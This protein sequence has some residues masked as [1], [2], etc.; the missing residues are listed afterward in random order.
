MCENAIA[1]VSCS[2][3]V[4]FLIFLIFCLFTG[5]NTAIS[6]IAVKTKMLDEMGK[7]GKIFVDGLWIADAYIFN[8]GR[9]LT[10]N[11]Q[12]QGCPMKSRSW[13]TCNEGCARPQDDVNELPEH[14]PLSSATTVS[15]KR[16]RDDSGGS[17]GGGGNSSSGGGSS[18]DG[19][20]SAHDNTAH[21]RN[22]KKVKVA[23]QNRL[24]KVL[25]AQE[26]ARRRKRAEDTYN[27]AISNAV[28][29]DGA[30]AG[31]AL[32]GVAAAAAAAVAP[33]QGSALLRGA[34]SAPNE[35]DTSEDFQFPDP[36]QTVGPEHL[37]ASR[38]QVDDHVVLLA[39][40]LLTGTL[41]VPGMAKVIDAEEAA[42]AEA[43][44]EFC[45]QGRSCRLATR[46][47]FLRFSHPDDH[48]YVR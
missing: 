36:K 43:K 47:H 38:A 35:V 44:K 16:S 11:L 9:M 48:V 15:K 4:S 32:A 20:G 30:Q 27:K 37:R 42:A 13:H 41:E 34:D 3:F 12:L 23:D 45:E 29:K 6:A 31:A 7:Q 18:S 14:P 25:V 2:L 19:G 21:A 40:Q 24:H 1:S 28:K 5:S 8:R 26:A 33:S 39:R 22:A 46:D 17:S 10:T